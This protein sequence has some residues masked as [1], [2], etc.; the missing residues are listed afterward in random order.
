MYKRLWH[1]G[2][3]GRFA[4]FRWPTFYGGPEA[5]DD[6]PLLGYTTYNDSEYRAWKAGQ[7]LALYVNQLATGYKRRIAAHSMGNIVVGSAFKY[8]M[9]ADSYALLNAAVPA[10]CYEESAQRRWPAFTGIYAWLTGLAGYSV[11][12]Q[13]PNAPD[14]KTP[15]DDVSSSIRALSYI[16][17]LDGI[18]ADVVNFY[19]ETDFATS[20]SWNA[21]NVIMRPHKSS[22][23]LYHYDW[24]A[25]P[26][27]HLTLNE[28]TTIEGIPTPIWRRNL[29]DPHEVMAYD[30]NVPTFTVNATG[31]TR[32]SIDTGIDMTAYGFGRNHSAQWQLRF[33]Q[34]AQF[35]HQLL[36][37]F[38]LTPTL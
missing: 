31:G 5:D 9:A 17:Q 30:C 36:I 26:D 38:G 4:A 8:G 6:D 10:L 24:N 29:S 12:S 32:G 33:H 11:P 14:S 28:I 2:Y 20:I 22:R 3:K 34:T 7:S 1:A 35:Y 27:R 13:S 19:L 16:R 15:V 21:N 37:E 23:A 18:S 25:S